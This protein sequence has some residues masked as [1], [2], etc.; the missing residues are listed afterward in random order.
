ML[1]EYIEHLENRKDRKE[2]S[3]REGWWWCLRDSVN[4]ATELYSCKLI[5]R[6]ILY[7]VKLTTLK[8]KNVKNRRGIKDAV[9][10]E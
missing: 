10:E 2:E 7:F 6:E 4:V 8:S 3:S 1:S 5:T 9:Q